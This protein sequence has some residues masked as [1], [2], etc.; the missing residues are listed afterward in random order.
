M[1]RIEN[2]KRTKKNNDEVEAGV[3]KSSIITR[4]AELVEVSSAGSSSDVG[5]F[6]A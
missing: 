6:A 5:G 3:G 1:G 4:K 2:S